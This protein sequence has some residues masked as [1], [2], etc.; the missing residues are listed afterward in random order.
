MDSEG[1]DRSVPHVANIMPWVALAF[2]LQRGTWKTAWI[3]ELFTTRITVMET[4][5]TCWIFSDTR[6]VVTLL[7]PFFC[8]IF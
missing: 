1:T 2:G 5:L 8:F 4:A 6:R 3:F 7:S